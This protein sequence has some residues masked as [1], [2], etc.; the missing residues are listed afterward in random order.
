MVGD[1]NA[2]SGQDTSAAGPAQVAEQEAWSTPGIKVLVVGI[3]GVLAAVAMLLIAGKQ[4]G[5]TATALVW[6]GVVVLTPPCW[7]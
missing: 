7:C 5:G 2:G 6:A 4:A 1:G 3:V